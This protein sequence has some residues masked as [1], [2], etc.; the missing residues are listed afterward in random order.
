M[1][2]NSNTIRLSAF[3]FASLSDV[4]PFG[5]RGCQTGRSDVGVVGLSDGELKQSE[6]AMAWTNI[7]V[8][9][10]GGEKDAQLLTVAKALAEPFNATI[11]MVYASPSPLSL[12]SW[13][14]EGSF[15]PT[16][17]AIRALQESADMGR[18]RC[19]ELLAALGYP[20]TVF[21]AVDA[22]DWL[23]LR[24]VSRL[25]DVVIWERS[26]TRGHGFFASA[27]QQI[28]LDE[29]RPAFIADKPLPAGGTIAIAWDGG[30]EA[31]RAL[32][33]AVP[34][35]RGAAKVVLL[36][37][38]HAMTHPCDGSR[39][40]DYL[41]DQGIRAE[42]TVLHTHGDAGPAILEAVK[43]VG[44]DLLVSGAFGHPRLQRFIFGG[45]TQFLLES[46]SG[47]ALFLSH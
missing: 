30:R 27:F 12:F 38:P 13:A 15:G 36:S 2:T 18:T 33:R 34:L 24:T 9:V 39:A 35:L 25:A 47:A 5:C 3:N 46:Q 42:S 6:G 26:A 28:L 10:L 21:E 32:R 1:L 43:N 11:T 4:C 17:V 37:V 23:G 31:S 19:R 40:V 20:K 8:P 16:D 7:L 22:E 14:G 44:A 29:R 45:T 41:A